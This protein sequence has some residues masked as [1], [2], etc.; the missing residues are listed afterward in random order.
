MGS[1]QYVSASKRLKKDEMPQIDTFQR[2]DLTQLE[3]RRANKIFNN[4]THISFLPN[5][6]KNINIIRGYGEQ[7]KNGYPFNDLMDDS[8]DSKSS[9]GKINT[10]ANFYKNDLGKEMVKSRI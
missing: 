3:N 9:K 8:L 7:N 10:M 4:S 6:S 1:S 2:K 5:D